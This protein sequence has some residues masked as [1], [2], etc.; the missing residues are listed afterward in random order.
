MRSTM[1][2]SA[3]FDLLCLI[4]GYES[5]KPTIELSFPLSTAVYLIRAVEHL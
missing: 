4:S 5:I 3:L 2:R 1:L